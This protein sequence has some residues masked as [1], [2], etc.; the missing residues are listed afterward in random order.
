M[1]TFKELVKSFYAHHA[2]EYDDWAVKDRS[3]ETELVLESLT[4]RCLEIGTGTGLV[5]EAMLLRGLDGY[6]IDFSLP[7][8]QQSMNCIQ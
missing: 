2:A 5:L 6:G 1:S 8:L 7:L 4:G 3:E